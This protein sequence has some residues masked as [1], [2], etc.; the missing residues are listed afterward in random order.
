[1]VVA[2]G[3]LGSAVGGA[4]FSQARAP[5]TNPKVSRSARSARDC[6][7]AGEIIHQKDA[8]AAVGATL[9][10]EKFMP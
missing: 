6:L 2:D 4:P 9:F 10:M 8:P 3:G 5:S 1:M 7:E